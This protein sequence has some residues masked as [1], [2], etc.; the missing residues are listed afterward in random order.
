L[1]L[2]HLPDKSSQVYHQ[3]E[4]LEKLKLTPKV[5]QY[6]EINL[7]AKYFDFIRNFQHLLFLKIVKN[8]KL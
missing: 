6:L 3:E 4:L 5:R 8:K 2:K 1:I 7:D